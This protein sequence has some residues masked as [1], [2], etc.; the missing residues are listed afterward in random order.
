MSKFHLMHCV[1]HPRMHGLHGYREVIESIAWGLEQ[2]GHEVSYALNRYEPAATN[3]VFGAQVLPMDFLARMAPGT[4]VYNFEQMRGLQKDSIRPEMHYCARHLQ[5]W[6]YSASNIDSW[7]ALGATAVRLVP[8]GYAPVLARIPKPPVQ[9]IDVLIYGM[10][11]DKRVNAFHR[12]SHAGL[13]VLFASGLYGEARDALIARSKVVLNINLYDHA[14]IFEIVRVSYLLANRKAVVATLDANTV[15]EG[16]L[17]QAIRFSTMDRLVD[18]C[19]A[20]VENPS[21]RA[22]LEAVAHDTFARRDIRQIL[23]S[24]LQ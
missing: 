17:S 13:V 16:D 7:A 3:I 8:V 9:D 5:V 12:L 15:M 24:A 6:E 21:E 4:V 23:Q 20:L 22:R 11:G 14:Q 10:S 19:A 18:D 1:P 2:L